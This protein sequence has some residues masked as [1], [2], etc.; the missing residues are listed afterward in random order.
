M[1]IFKGK[2]DVRIKFSP[3]WTL[4]NFCMSSTQII[5][6]G[7]LLRQHL[8]MFPIRHHHIGLDLFLILDHNYVREFFAFI[9]SLHI[10]SGLLTTIFI[11]YDSL[12]ARCC[13]C[14]LGEG[15]YN[16]TVQ[17]IV[18]INDNGDCTSISLGY[19]NLKK[20]E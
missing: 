7:L 8:I 16:G 19:S 15:E 12:F 11:F 2:K 10:F 6:I 20:I 1:S 18:S 4:V 3:I 5:V 14:C 13:S 17:N 9:V